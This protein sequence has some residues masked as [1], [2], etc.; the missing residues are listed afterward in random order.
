MDVMLHLLL[1]VNNARMSTVDPS[2]D[3]RPFS[4]RSIV[5]SVLLGSHPP[6]MSVG[7]LLE[8][9]SLFDIPDGTIRTALSRMAAAGELESAEGVYRLGGR[10]LDRQSQQ[11]EG[12]AVPP[13]AWDGDWWVAVVLSERRSMADR[14]SFRSRAQGARLGE[15]RPDTWLR[16]ANI[17]IPTDLGDVAL[18][19]GN[20]IAGSSEE[21]VGRLWDLETLDRQARH[22]LTRVDQADELLRAEKPVDQDLA[23][24][25]TILATSLRYLRTEPQLPAEL[26]IGTAGNDLRAHH[27]ETELRFQQQLAAFFRRRGI[28]TAAP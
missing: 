27:R 4:A 25:F 17:D 11:D 8:F 6:K 22:L 1:T 5:L 28:S 14:R 3:L 10:M 23:A 20:L 19:R 24:A 7:P 13:D 18:T 21:L 15:L 26:A 16:P 2:L 12:R 9:T